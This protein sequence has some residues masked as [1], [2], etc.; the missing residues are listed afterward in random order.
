MKFRFQIWV[1]VELD[2][3]QDECSTEVAYE[4]MRERLMT[5]SGWSDTDIM[6]CQDDKVGP[7]YLYGAPAVV[8]KARKAYLKSDKAHRV[9]AASAEDKCTHSVVV[10]GL[11]VCMMTQVE[12]QSLQAQVAKEQAE[13]EAAE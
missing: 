1:D 3:E 8:Q 5:L 12:L 13:L 6:L 2:D 11:P 7:E 10:N 4:L 9:C